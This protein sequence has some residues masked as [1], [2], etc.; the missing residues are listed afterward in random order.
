MGVIDLAASLSSG[1]AIWTSRGD[2]G[3]RA[4]GS[5][6][7]HNMKYARTEAFKDLGV[8]LL[9]WGANQTPSAFNAFSGGDNTYLANTSAV[10]SAAVSAGVA[11]RS[12]HEALKAFTQQKRLGDILNENPRYF[13]G[14]PELARSIEHLK[15]RMRSHIWLGLA[16]G[17]GAVLTGAGSLLQFQPPGE[18]PTEDVPTRVRIGQYISYAGGTVALLLGAGKAIRK[19]RKLADGPTSRPHE[20]VFAEALSEHGANGMEDPF[21]QVLDVLG[22]NAEMLNQNRE[23]PAEIRM[24]GETLY[25]NLARMW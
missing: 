22:V 25:K 2:V 12:F 9:D 14:K 21:T 8:N 18:A 11:L 20:S 3:G 23:D 5:L 15:E 6:G 16:G 24:Q 17:T 1:N 4:G 19:L 13:E 10:G 7:E